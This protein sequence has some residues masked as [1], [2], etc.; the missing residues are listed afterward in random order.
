MILNVEIYNGH[1]RQTKSLDL[2]VASLEET[3][4]HYK[5]SGENRLRDPAVEDLVLPP[6]TLIFYSCIYKTGFL[7]SDSELV[8]EYLNQ[9]EFFSYVPESK[10][11]VT[12]S[13]KCTVVSLD[14]LV[15]RILRTYPSLVRDFHF[16]L[17]ARES[18]LFSAVRYSVTDDYGKGVDIKVQYN[19]KWYNVGLCLSSKRSL[20]YK[21]KK[22]FRH[23][24]T[25][26]I[27]IELQQSEANMVGDYMLYTKKHLEQIIQRVR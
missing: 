21:A 16:Y 5:Y 24:P 10:V 11:E 18:N 23:R 6:I 25:D 8:E 3:L 22:A 19:D 13:G 26:I 4:Q 1:I 15:G 14:G 27:H 7:P 20:F 12:Y 17:M 2:T 9:K